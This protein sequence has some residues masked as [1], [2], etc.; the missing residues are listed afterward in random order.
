MARSPFQRV[1]QH[2]RREA[3]LQTNEVH[4]DADLLR[5]FID[6]QDEA[7]FEMIV[8]RHGPMVMGVCGRVLRNPH[9]AEDAFQAT[10]LVLV[11]KAAAIA[12]RA[13]VG[14]WL[15]GVARITALRARAAAAKRQAKET[16]AF[17]KGRSG[18]A[19]SDF[20]NVILPILD[21]EI[22]RLPDK[23]RI[24]VILCDLE[25]RTLRDVATQLGW[26]VGTVAGRLARARTMLARR[27][28]RNGASLSGAMVAS[29]LADHAN[30]AIPV[31]L[32]SATVTGASKYALEC[33][34]SSGFVS[35]RVWALTEGVCRAM[36]LSKVRIGAALL[37]V[38]LVGLG[39][40]M[41]VYASYAAE[42]PRT[43][44]ASAGATTALEKQSADEQPNPV[45]RYKTYQ[46]DLRIA[47]KTGE[48]NTALVAEP[49]LTMREGEEGTF[50]SGGVVPV[51]GDR[52]ETT[53]WVETG[54]RTGVRV[55]GREDGRV[56]VECWLEK[57]EMEKTSEER[58]EMKS[59]NTRSIRIVKLGESID[60]SVEGEEGKTYSANFNVVDEQF[61][62]I[63][64]RRAK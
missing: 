60:L 37:A 58:F 18:T 24:P 5:R 23:Y 34:A 2:A 42:P 22:A 40:G 61:I 11:R 31:S 14:N 48:G 32:R 7:A 30:A 38:C 51:P 43:H 36:V 29:L 63:S 55:V 1:V 46:V 62:T 13:Q 28:T 35:A 49:A 52:P 9:D 20:W 50:I 33:A 3:L 39:A 44:Q 12:P 19:P 59:R 6:R 27:L 57:S 8:R 41:S 25:N 15:H 47:T 45:E 21:E 53:G 56:R 10:F 17:E 16:M 4:P 64:R 26:P 54:V